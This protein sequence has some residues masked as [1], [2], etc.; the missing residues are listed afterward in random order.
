MIVHDT[1]GHWKN[2]TLE[3]SSNIPLFPQ[4]IGAKHKTDFRFINKSD[5]C[6]PLYTPILNDR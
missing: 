1:T 2:S 4:H 3:Q 6:R 5:G